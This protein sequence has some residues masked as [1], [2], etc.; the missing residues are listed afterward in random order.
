[1]WLVT[2]PHHSDIRI[3]GITPEERLRRVL[4]ATG[5]A[6]ASLHV[7]SLTDIPFTQSDL[8]VFR[9]EYV[10]DERLI[11]ALI[12]SM[13]TLLVLPSA[14]NEKG[15]VVAARVTAAHAAGV[16]AHLRD[17]SVSALLPTAATH[18]HFVSPI[19]LVPAYSAA[20]RKTDPPYVFQVRKEN[21]A[22]IENRTFAASYKGL[23]DLVTKFV[24]PRPA[25]HVVRWAA[26]AGIT[27]N[28]ITVVS[29]LLV[30]VATWLFLLGDFGLG[31]VVAWIMTF[32]DTV[33][34]KLA[35]V[36]LSSSRIGHVLDHGLDI[37]H[38]PF[39]YLA[40]TMGLLLSPDGGALSA[41]SDV[42]S[43]LRPAGMIT[44]IG[45]IVGRVIEGLF[46]LAFKMEIHCWQPIDGFFRLITARRNPNLLLL[47]AATL[48]GRPDLG[49]VLVALWTLFSI[50]FHA[51]RLL[52]ACGQ[53]LRGRPVLV[54]QEAMLQSAP[55]N[56][57][58][59]LQRP[60]ESVA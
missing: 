15:R 33:D 51:V 32:L 44:V 40:W 49:I 27:P 53:R 42:T 16:L 46:M 6:N 23:T 37:L 54:W 12:E 38:P 13:E 55:D 2:E 34:G 20:L 31:L 35:R 39:W 14:V 7:G 58:G 56:T 29:W 41:S 43:W 59:D 57:D 21:I 9:A 24:W 47:S 45:Y 50:G 1:V 36:T 11:R 25:Q 5:V 48:Y 17:E 3:W 52:Q 18:L 26:N 30:G 22:E 10:F 8:L 28:V 4:C 60:G 19:E